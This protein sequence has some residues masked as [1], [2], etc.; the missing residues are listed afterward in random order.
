MNEQK[1][2]LSA[3]SRMMCLGLFCFHLQSSR[4]HETK[5]MMGVK[6][7]AVQVRRFDIEFGGR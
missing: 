4:Q 6:E 2:D 1:G 5:R 3:S 7:A